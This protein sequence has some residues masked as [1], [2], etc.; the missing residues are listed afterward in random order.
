M[1]LV[2]HSVVNEPVHSSHLTLKDTRKDAG[3]LSLTNL[4]GVTKSLTRKQQM[5][6]LTILHVIF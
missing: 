6:L 4:R 1:T 3:H 5:I 2:A